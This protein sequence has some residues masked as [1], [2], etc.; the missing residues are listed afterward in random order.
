MLALIRERFAK[1]KPLA[2]R[3]HRRVPAR[4]QR[5]REP[6]AHADR[7][8]GRAGA[9][10]LQPAL[11]SGRRGRGAGGRSTASPPS[12]SRA[13]TATPTT[14]TSR[15]SSTSIRRSPWTTAPT[16]W[17]C[18]TPSAPTPPTGVIGGTEE[19]TTGV[20]RLKS[21]EQDG[22]LRYPIVAVN[23]AMTKHMFD[24]RYGTGQSTLDGIIRATN[25]LIAGKIVVD[26]RLRLV[27]PGRGHAGQGPR[28]RRGGAGGR[29][30]AGA[31]SHHGRLPGHAHGRGRADRR[32]LRHRHRR[33]PRDPQGALRGHEGRRHRRQHRPLQRG[34]RHPGAGGPV[35]GHAA[36]VREFVEE[37]T[38]ADG[39][40]V[41]LLG[42]GRLINLAA[43]EGHPS[44]VMDMSFANQA[45][46]AEYMVKNAASLEKTRLRRPGGH[47]PGDRPAEA[48]LAGHRHRQAHARAGGVP[49]QLEHGDLI[50]VRHR[51]R[52]GGPQARAA[53]RRGRG[54][55][56][57]RSSGTTAWW[58]MIDQRRLPL[59]EV[60]VR[61][62]HLAGGGGRH[63]HH[64]GA[65]RS[66][67]RGGRR[68]GHG[69]GRPG[70]AR[71]TSGGDPAPLPRRPPSCIQRPIR[72]P[73]HGRITFP[74]RSE[75]WS[76]SGAATTSRRP[77]S[78]KHGAAGRADLRGRPGFVPGHRRVRG[79]SHHGGASRWY[80]HTATR[81][82]WPRPDTARRWASSG[83]P[84]PATPGCG[85]WPT[86]PGRCCRAP[87]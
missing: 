21:M 77:R 20:I 66:R 43:A 84:M 16:W 38:L 2:G 27:R 62:A 42:E 40:N 83:R 81:G 48:G 5:D 69:A 71:A 85:C 39:R 47:R 41:Y 74:G 51:R 4:D 60:Y 31:R 58:C 67:S 33:H 65:R 44:S 52:G 45:L 6:H 19:T 86:R 87:G 49:G 80:S 24:N 17:A 11:H 22:V 72:D 12:P 55:H 18:C 25:R 70:R 35:D 36:Q 63:L 1:E 7:R 61:C 32:H 26:R 29:P 73:A 3:P 59:E 64:G 54:Q 53:A 9:L 56:P 57:D 34:D 23:E 76:A 82:L 46:A 15:A 37:F 10:R 13:R 14:A 78:P 68:H 8:R 75:R 79:R 50:D 30:A 28:R